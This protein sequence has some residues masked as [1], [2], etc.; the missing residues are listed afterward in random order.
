MRLGPLAAVIAGL[1]GSPGCS[2]DE[3]REIASVREALP[4]LWAFLEELGAGVETGSIG[5]NA[6]L[7]ERCRRFYTADRMAEIEAVVPGWRRMASYADGKT[8]WHVNVAMLA[9]LRL[10]E[11]RSLSPDRRIVQE[12]VVLLHDLAKEPVEGRDHRHAFRSAAQAGRVLPG[13]GFPVTDAYRSE[14]PGW[15]DLVDT[16]T[17]FDEAQDLEIH[18]N[19][20]LGEILDGA[21]RI[22]PEPTRSAVGA[23]ALH[24]SITSLAA[25]PVKAPLTDAQ[26]AA[27]LD[28]DVLPVLAALTLADSGGWNLFAPEAL[29]AMYAETRAV[30]REL[31][32]PA[33]ERAAGRPPGP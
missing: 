11:Y 33:S 21:A 1:M 8:L 26:V 5:S 16:A 18:D 32:R 4:E 22:F 12:W 19:A 27:Y 7:V 14:F 15:S 29:K 9:L 17:R 24:Q 13:L 6:E 10:D 3:P 30:F 28:R 25:W 23:I 20:R 2:G 31:P